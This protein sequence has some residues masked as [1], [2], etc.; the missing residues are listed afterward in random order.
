MSKIYDIASKEYGVKEIVGKQHNSE[1]LKYFSEIGHAWV[2]ND[3]M[4]WCSAFVNWCAKEAKLEFSGALNARSWLDIGEEVKTPELGDIVVL[5][6][7][8]RYGWKGHVGIYVNTI[9]NYIYLLGG[10]QNNQVKTQAYPKSRVLSY[11]RLKTKT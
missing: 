8:R 7:E 6:R 1:V 5:W 11:R 4:A 10:N 3:E 9:G 2:K